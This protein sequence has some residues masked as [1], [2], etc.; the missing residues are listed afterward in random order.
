[1]TTD[2]LSRNNGRSTLATIRSWIKTWARRFQVVVLHV[3]LLF[4][5]RRHGAQLPP[6]RLDSEDREMLA[7]REFAIKRRKRHGPIFKMFWG[8]RYTTCVVGH[9]HVRRLLATNENSFP[10]E[11]IDLTSLFPI[12]ALR[13]MVGENHQKYRRLFILA[14][15]ATPLAAHEGA[16]R[17]WIDSRLADL[18]NASAGQAISGSALKAE[19]REIATGIM[20]CLLYGVPPGSAEYA[21]LVTEHRVFGPEAPT[22]VIK[23]AHAAAFARIKQRLASL[24]DEIRR[25]PAGTMAPSFLKYFVDTGTLDKTVEGNLIYLIESSHFDTF[26]LWRWI[27]R[28]LASNP[29]TMA[30]VRASTGE[31][32]RDLCRAIVFETLRLEQSEVLYRTPVDDVVFDNYLIPKGS[33]MRGCLWE[34][35]KDEKIF[36]EP[37][38][39]DP[40]RFLGRDY[41]IE[42]YAPFGLDKTRCIGSSL[43][44]DLGGIFV[45]ILLKN[46]KVTLVADGPPVMGQ[47]HWEPNPG[48]SVV[49]TRLGES[50]SGQA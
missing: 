33:I 48:F 18:A 1:M 22:K 46:F 27:T 16:L 45:E 44:I 11:T 12:G 49:L 3:F 17:D 28:F 13:G 43:V 41:K 32:M 14:L 21:A 4:R 25:A 23:P 35:H 10:D 24:I 6:G 5:A 47:Y 9:N 36:P 26:S 31:E 20:M 15:Q 39:F 50:D 37:F 8:N 19:L 42:E 7:D 2:L 34:G 29:A 38:K 30:R 40:D